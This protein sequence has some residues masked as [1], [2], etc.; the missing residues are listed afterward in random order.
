MTKFQTALKVATDPRWWPFYLQR[1]VLDPARRAAIAGLLA[2]RRPPANIA[3]P[4]TARLAKD[5]LEGSGIHHLGA[6]LTPDQ[7]SELRDHFSRRAVFDPYRPSHVEFLPHSPERHP[8]AH[9]AHHHP[10]DILAAPHL[11]DLANDPRMLD[12]AG[13]YL[14]CRPT[15]G[16]MACWWSY[17]TAIGPQ[18]AEFLHRDVD[19]WRFLK[20]FVYLSDVGAESGPHIYIRA[21]GNDPRFLQLR[22][23]DDADVIA[24]FGQDAVMTMTGKAGEAFFENTFGI[25]KGQ[26]VAKGTRLIFQVVYSLSTLPYSPRRPTSANPD[27]Q[28]FD[29]W[30]NRMYL[31]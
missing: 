10:E 18:Q 22:R 8:D 30:I 17:A 20:L 4:A 11:L 1:R 26:P 16:Y 24:G 3:A 15:I 29:P 27:P 23:F 14:G 25:H 19:D 13:A 2:R 7:S 6:V 5:N 31:R 28:R 12:I 21:S 9:I